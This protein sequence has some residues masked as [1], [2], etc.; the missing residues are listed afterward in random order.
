MSNAETSR[1]NLI[2]WKPGQSGNPE[3]HS[4]ARRK[5]KRLRE[6]LDLILEQEIPPELLLE[7]SERV[8]GSLP[9]GVT[10]AEAIALR[11]SLLAVTTL[12]SSTLLGAASAILNAQAKPDVSIRPILAAAPKLPSTDERRAA[13][14]AQ[15]G[16]EPE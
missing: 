2:P 9:T 4:K 5:A 8:R 13:V 14:A 6:A 11:V 10:F 12:D 1:A 3:G 7:I 16:L 15:L